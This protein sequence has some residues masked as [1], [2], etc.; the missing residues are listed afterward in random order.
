MFAPLDGRFR[1]DA[2]TAAPMRRATRDGVVGTDDLASDGREFGPQSR[3]A[4]T[5]RRLNNAH[6]TRRP[7]AWV[8]A[9][10][11]NG[12]TAIAARGYC[13]VPCPEPPL[14]R[15]SDAGEKETVRTVRCTTNFAVNAAERFARP[16]FAP[17]TRG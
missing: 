10:A 1:S 9:T 12:V 6:V 4:A 8:V 13:T 16:E 5:I 14:R 17:E 11:G 15:R 3:S 2:A 7:I